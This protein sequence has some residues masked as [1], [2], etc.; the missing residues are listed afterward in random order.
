ME[1][2]ILAAKLYRACLG[3]IL[4]IGK[5]ELLKSSWFAFKKHKRKMPEAAV[6]QQSKEAA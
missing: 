3:A 2:K 5:D 1:D 4:A 6:P